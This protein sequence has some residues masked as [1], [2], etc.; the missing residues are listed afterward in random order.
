MFDDEGYLESRVFPPVHKIV[1]GLCRGDLRQTL[2][3]SSSNID[4]LDMDGRTALSWTAAKS[5]ARAVEILLEFGANPNVVSHRGHGPLSWAA[6]SREPG[7]RDVVEKLL[8]S[9]ADANWADNNNRTPLINSTSD[10]DDPECLRLLIDHG[11][12]INW[13]DCHRR[14]AVCYA[15]KM[16]RIAN[17]RYLLEVGA[18]YSI[19]DHWGHTPHIEA[20][21]QNHHA[22]LE[23]LLAKDPL[24]LPPRLA[25]SRTVSHIAAAHA[26]AKTFHLL[27][28]KADLSLCTLDDIDNDGHS[29]QEVFEARDLVTEELRTAFKRFCL[30]VVM[31]NSCPVLTNPM[32]SEDEFVDALE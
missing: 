27:A 28:D 17:L 14:T 30:E 13:Q 6:Q 21:Y 9:S 10:V 32:D 23:V 20:M 22:A 5:D 26:D 31:E 8:A 7:R 19:P 12:E 11:A 3:M 18:D 2:E 24:L 4:D 25:D 16:N 1:L 15:A 29:F